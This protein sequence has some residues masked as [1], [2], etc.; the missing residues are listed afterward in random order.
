VIDRN[1]LLHA[2]RLECSP[3]NLPI[4]AAD[5]SVRIRGSEGFRNVAEILARRH[6]TKWE[7]RV[8]TEVALECRGDARGY[9]RIV[10]G[11]RILIVVLELGRLRTA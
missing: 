10:A 2:P 3:V 9:V 7:Y 8:D 6:A 11:E 1:V 4:R 5:A